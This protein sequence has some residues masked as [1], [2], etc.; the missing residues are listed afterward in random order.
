M[1]LSNNRPPPNS[2]GSE[3]A[4]AGYRKCGTFDGTP[5]PE[6]T[7]ECADVKSG[8]Y[9]YVYL[10]ETASMTLCEVKA[11]SGN[12]PAAGMLIMETL[13]YF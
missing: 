7:L 4:G 3:L 11:F 8:R 9:L 12:M 1:V 2:G 13:N 5:A 10:A 6:V